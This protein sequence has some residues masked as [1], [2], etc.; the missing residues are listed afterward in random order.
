MLLSSLPQVVLKKSELYWMN[1]ANDLT[2]EHLETL[3]E[4]K[5]ALQD[6]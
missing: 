5:R 2:I 1:V 3:T 6:S 4:L